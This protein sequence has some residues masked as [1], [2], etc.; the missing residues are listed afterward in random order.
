MNEVVT[1]LVVDDNLTNRLLPALILRDLGC[2]VHESKDADEALQLLSAHRFSH[3]LL[4]IS[5]PKISGIELCD[6]IR[7][8]EG[9]SDIKIIAYTSHAQASRVSQFISQGFDEVLIKPIKKAHLIG[10]VF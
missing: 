2:V 5:M 9:G 7:A 1:V 10:A 4:D 3:V 8:M 6:M